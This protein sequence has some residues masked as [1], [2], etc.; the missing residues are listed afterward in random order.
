MMENSP[1][2]RAPPSGAAPLASAMRRVALTIVELESHLT[3][4]LLSAEA[5]TGSEPRQALLFEL[6]SEYGSPVARVDSRTQESRREDATDYPGLGQF[7]PYI[8]QLMIL[9][10]KSTQHRGVITECREIW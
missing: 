3:L 4:P 6:V 2:M 5:V 9:I 7:G 1:G 8:Q 10:L